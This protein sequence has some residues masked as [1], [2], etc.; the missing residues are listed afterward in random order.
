M[1][2]YIKTCIQDSIDTK[3]RLYE[4]EE[5]LDKIESAATACITAYKAGGKV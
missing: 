5:L 2:E 1:R 4:N 3:R